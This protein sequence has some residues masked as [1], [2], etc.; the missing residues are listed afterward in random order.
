MGVKRGHF[1]TRMCSV[2]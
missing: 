1:Y 2:S